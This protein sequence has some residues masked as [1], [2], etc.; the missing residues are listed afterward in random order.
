MRIIHL[1]D[2]H[3]CKDNIEDFRLHYR[4]S[5]IEE[6]KKINFEKEIDLII[7]S[8]D[9]VDR[10]GKSLLELDEYKSLNNPYEVFEKEFIDSICCE[11]P[12]LKENVIFIA[13]NHDIEVNKINKVIEAGLNSLI[14][15]SNN[16]NEVFNEYKSDKN[17]LGID[18]MNNFLN[19]EEKY[20]SANKNLKYEFSEFESKVIY[21]YDGKKI[22]IAL[23]ND[24]WRCTQKKVSEHFISTHQ[25]FR[26]LNFFD[27][28]KTKFNIVV[29]HHPLNLM[30]ETEKEAIEDILQYKNFK[31]LLI[32]HEHKKRVEIL[33]L[34]EDNIFCVRGRTAFDKPHEK[35]KDYISGFSII[36]I[37]FENFKIIGKFK[38]YNKH[39]FEFDDEILKG[40][41]YEEF[42]FG[43]RQN[44][45]QLSKNDFIN[46]SDYER[47]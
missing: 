36:D 20:H 7:I 40:R 4:K 8:G 13:G 9:L 5:L 31:L 34:N 44:L 43:V 41:N 17:F 14:T 10:G 21:E 24:S 18:R 19:F 12:F 26:C 29:M 11:I 35:E 3:L 15:D 37:D 22:G 30:E 33:G 23:I 46:S 39:T 38:I 6:F 42:V 25:F 27:I 2:I 16:A 1:S 32:G 28:E 47:E 45:Q